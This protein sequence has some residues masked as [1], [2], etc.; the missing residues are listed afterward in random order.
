MESIAIVF[1]GMPQKIATGKTLQQMINELSLTS[2]GS[3]FAV[4]NQV[5]PRSEWQTRVLCEGDSIS[6]F[7][8]IAGG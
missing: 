7:Q 8:A 3:V 4:N 2:H 6:L 5:V 1:N